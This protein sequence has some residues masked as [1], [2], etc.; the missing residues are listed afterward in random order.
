MWLRLAP[1]H[2]LLSCEACHSAIAIWHKVVP[3]SSSSRACNHTSSSCGQSQWCEKTIHTCICHWNWHM[4]LN[5]LFPI[6][7]ALAAI[8]PYC[9]RKSMGLTSAASLVLKTHSSR[10]FSAPQWSH[11]GAVIFHPAQHP[12]KGVVVQEPGKL[13]VRCFEPL[14]HIRRKIT[15]VRFQSATIHG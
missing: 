2:V 13:L 12:S 11:R 7:Q 14:H 9:V 10:I 4:L 5:A 3:L 15:L 8:C 1:R 6:L